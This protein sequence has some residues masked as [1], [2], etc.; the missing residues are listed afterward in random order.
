MCTKNEL[1]FSI[2]V[3]YNL[4]QAW[5]KTP[6]EVYKL[7]NDTKILDDYVIGCYDTLHTLGKDYLVD[8]IT[9]FAR[10]RGI[11]V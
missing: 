1:S 3:L 4:A 10:E 11:A 5:N 7:L 8:D 9:G 2:F 6:Y